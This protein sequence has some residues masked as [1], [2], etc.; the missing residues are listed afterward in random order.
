MCSILFLQLFRDICELHVMLCYLRPRAKRPEAEAD[1]LLSAA[2]LRSKSSELDGRS[3]FSDLRISSS[4]ADHESKH[5]N[6]REVLETFSSEIS[7][8]SL[9]PEGRE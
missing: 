8:L 1:L 9:W 4:S 3:E 6:Q 7:E 5:E 2:G